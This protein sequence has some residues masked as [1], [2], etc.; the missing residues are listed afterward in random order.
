M[1]IAVRDLDLGYT[2]CSDLN[3]HAISS[4][5]KLI[6]D[7]GTIITN[8]KAHWIGSDATVHINNLIKVYNG[9]VTVV[10]DAKIVSSNAG[11]AIIAIQEVR[12]S[13]GGSANVGTILPKNAPDSITFQ[14]NENTME[15]KC[16]PAAKTDYQQLET[17]CTD[18]ETFKTKFESIKNDLMSNW[19]AG[20]NREGAVKV[21]E[22][23]ATNTETYKAY[24]TSAR[25]DLQIAVSNLSQL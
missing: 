5:E 24:L 15:Y 25:D 13:N 6:G 14:N 11:S 18:F 9:V 20:A 22:D 2:Q 19:T 10:T 8:L 16:D 1:N 4:G 12:R 21:F 23:F 3:S 7:L 17:V